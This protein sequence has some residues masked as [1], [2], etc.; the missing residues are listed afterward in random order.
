[1]DQRHK[2]LIQYSP[3]AGF[4]FHRGKA[5]WAERGG[6]DQLTSRREPHNKYDRCAARADWRG[7]KL[8]YVPRD[9]NAAVA[10]LLVQGE[11][12]HMQAAGLSEG[13][14]PWPRQSRRFAWEARIKQ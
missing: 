7:W 9:E 12:L 6:G 5:L 3:T 14:S 4:Q 1:M 8:G 2:I 10:Q 13:P 11:R